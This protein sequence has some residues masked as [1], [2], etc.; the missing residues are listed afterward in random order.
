MKTIIITVVSV[1][2]VLGIFN[3]V[4]LQNEAYKQK[5]E[6]MTKCA[7][8]GGVYAEG[9]AGWVHKIITCNKNF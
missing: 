8:V 7:E 6:F 3:L 1:V 2:V 9:Q 4:S 5:A